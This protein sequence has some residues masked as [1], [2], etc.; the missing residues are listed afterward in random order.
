MDPSLFLTSTG[1]L[2]EIQLENKHFYN[3]YIQ[4][5]LHFGIEELMLTLKKMSLFCNHCTEASQNVQKFESPLFGLPSTFN[6]I[7]AYSIEEESWL[8]NQFTLLEKAFRSVSVS[9]SSVQEFMMAAH[10]V[11]LPKHHMQTMFAIFLE[12]IWRVY[13]I[14]PEFVE[15]PTLLQIELIATN[16]AFGLAMLI[17][18]A[19]NCVCFS[20]Q[21]REGIG[22]L[23]EQRWQQ[24]YLPLIEKVENAQPLRMKDAA[25]TKSVQ[26]SVE[27]FQNYQMM[28]KSYSHL[29]SEPWLFKICLL[30]ILTLPLDSMIAGRV[31]NALHNKYLTI[32][33]RRFNWI[34]LKR[35]SEVQHGLR[36]R[37]DPEM[38]VAKVMEGIQNLKLLSK[39]TNQVLQERA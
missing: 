39:I 27:D 8:M 7:N 23:D 18:K 31:G 28:T 34:Y 11:P 4:G 15:M 1:T 9:E 3:N 32:L 17:L 36:V 12:R 26:M 10:G 38:E 21:L 6:L 22:E 35:S 13:R 19:E 33:R 16:S 20:E 2:K 37:V 30:L 5:S 24:L 29:V 25:G 14:H